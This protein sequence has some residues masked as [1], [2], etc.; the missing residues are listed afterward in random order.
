ML[1]PASASLDWLAVF[2]AC[3]LGVIQGF[4]EF[5]PI[6]SSGHLVLISELFGW[7]YYGKSFDLLLHG[8]S[9]LAVLYYFRCDIPSCARGA[10]SFVRSGCKVWPENADERL[11]A[12]VLVAMVPTSLS[13]FLLDP[14]VEPFLQSRVL[15]AVMLGVFG[16]LLGWSDRRAERNAAG[17][18]AARG[19]RIEQTDWK[20]GLRLGLAQALAFIPGV[21]RSGI[22][23]TAA[24]WLGFDRGQAVRLSMLMSVPVIAGALSVKAATGAISAID[25]PWQAVWLALLAAFGCSLLALRMLT[26]LE[27]ILQWSAWY[28]VALAL[29]ILLCL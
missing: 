10:W 26:R 5:L 28:R 1:E 19:M 21:S 9:L 23:L 25:L 14:W 13:G 8:G 3:V 16:I 7:P 6:S 29:S 24:R 15:L 20:T 27:R 17:E 11:G 22:C 18:C 2:H 4:T 12:A